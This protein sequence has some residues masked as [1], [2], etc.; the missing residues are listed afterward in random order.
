MRVAVV[1]TGWWG[2]EHARAFTVAQHAELVAIVGRDPARTAAR[3]AQFGVPGYVDLDQ[4]LSAQTP[5]LVSVAVHSGAHYGVASRLLERRQRVLVEK[6]LTVDLAQ[7][8]VLVETAER[9]G[10]FLGVNFNYRYAHPVRLARRAIQAGN[11]GEIRL[12]AWQMSGECASTTPFANLRETQCHGFDLLEYLCGPVVSVSA[13]MSGAGTPGRDDSVIVTMVFG[14]GAIGS[15]VST[16]CATYSYPGAQSLLLAG[17]RGRVLIQDTVRRY[18]FTEA[19]SE[20]TTTWESGYFNDR[21]R[22]F[23]ATLDQHLVEVIAAVRAGA[24]PPVPGRAGLRALELAEAAIRA[25]RT[26]ARVRPGG[27]LNPAG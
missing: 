24:P 25:Y 13:E 27:A 16:S 18:S 10:L 20:H 6:P 23:T 19:G 12:A 22:Q 2:T 11:V 1:G 3:A 26:G 9:E 15:L 21:D 7:A 14:N 8:R 5:D 17:D 4:M